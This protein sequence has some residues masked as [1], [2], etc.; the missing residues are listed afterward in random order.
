M[1]WE[2]L[3]W[4]VLFV[5]GA[6]FL[7]FRTTTGEM[8]R[9]Y[10]QPAEAKWVEADPAAAAAGAAQFSWG[11]TLGLWTA[12]LMTLFVFSFLYRDNPLYK[13]AES[14]VVGVSAAYWMVVAFWTTLVPNLFAKLFPAAIQDWALPGTSPLR[15]D[16]RVW[17]DPPEWVF[18]LVP[19]VLGV[20]LLW[21]LMPAGGWIARWPL[22]FIIG[23]TAGLRLIG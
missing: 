17:F 22:A 9:A 20:M 11:R 6:A 2:T 23:T 15:E 7:A 12:A 14:L 19:L 16:W 8:G 4:T 10:V 5:A 18:Y 1:K 3:I 21:R 13:I